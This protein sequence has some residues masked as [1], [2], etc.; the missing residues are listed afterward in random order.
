M[1]WINIVATVVYWDNGFYIEYEG[2]LVEDTYYQFRHGEVVGNI[3][4]GARK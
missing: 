4:E 3:F 2:S 1:N